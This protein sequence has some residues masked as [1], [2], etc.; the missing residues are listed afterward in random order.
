MPIL[1]LELEQPACCTKEANHF[2][3]CLNAFDAVHPHQLILLG[4]D[5]RS[6]Q[7]MPPTPVPNLL[8]DGTHQQRR[9]SVGGGDV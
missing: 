4:L 2:A 7:S 1:V 9:F 6:G 8:L 5:G 3:V